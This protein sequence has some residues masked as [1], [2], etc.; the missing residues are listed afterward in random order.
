MPDPTTPSPFFRTLV[1]TFVATKQSTK[2]TAADTETATHWQVEGGDAKATAQKT[3]LVGMETESRT[4]WKAVS[5]KGGGM[6]L[7][8]FVR[9]SA[10]VPVGLKALP[11]HAEAPAARAKIAAQKTEVTGAQTLTKTQWKVD[12]AGGEQKL[13][14]TAQSSKLESFDTRTRTRWVLDE[15]LE[16]LEGLKA[17]LGK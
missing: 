7:D 5:A 17:L 10:V 8:E 2:V 1:Q 16:N 12:E 3:K 9:G 11:V 4:D 14:A 15:N 13:T 6:G